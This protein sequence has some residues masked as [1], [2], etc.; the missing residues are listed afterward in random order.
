MRLCIQTK[1]DGPYLTVSHLFPSSSCLLLFLLLFL[2]F[3]LFLL[4]SL[5][6]LLFLI[7]LFLLL[8]RLFLLLF[9]LLLLLF[10]LFILLL[11]HLLLRADP[12]SALEAAQQLQLK[13]QKMHDIETENQTLRETLEG[14]TKE[15]AEVKNHG[16]SP[17][18][19]GPPLLTTFGSLDNPNSVKK[20]RNK[21]PVFIFRGLKTTAG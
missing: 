12:V 17:P 9:F 7:S 10:L 16:E 19:S 5:L 3:L 4:L 8:F 13:V 15:S 20:N 14:Y 1:T 6:F 21:N 11:F 18:S 2:L